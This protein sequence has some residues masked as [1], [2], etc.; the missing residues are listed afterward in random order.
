[1]IAQGILDHG[2]FSK[3]SG[4]DT[5]PNEA[6]Y[7]MN[8]ILSLLAECCTD[9]RVPIVISRLIINSLTFKVSHNELDLELPKHQEWAMEIFD[10]IRSDLIQD[11]IKVL[12][13]G[14]RISEDILVSTIKKHID[15][16][17]YNDGALMIVR[18][19]FN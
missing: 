15:K 10:T 5:K 13:L 2:Y 6:D 7:L 18:Y 4:A 3:L 12:K 17:K 9:E 16:G 1:M 8:L 11:Y 14:D 19:G